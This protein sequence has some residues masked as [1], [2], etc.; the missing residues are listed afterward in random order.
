MEIENNVVDLFGK[1]N[2]AEKPGGDQDTLKDKWLSA[3]EQESFKQTDDSLIEENNAKA[4]AA[5]RAELELALAQNQ[6]L[7]SAQS[8]LRGVPQEGFPS[9]AQLMSPAPALPTAYGPT[10]RPGGELPGMP[11]RPTPATNAALTGGA[12]KPPMT[13]SAPGFVQ[14]YEAMVNQARFMDVNIQ[15]TQ[16]KDGV[17]LWIRDCKQKYSSEVFQW[18]NSLE[19]LL[20]ENGQSLSR[21]MLNGKNI[22]NINAIFGG[23]HGN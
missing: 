21:I 10:V 5:Q 7:N 15:L 18:T 22:N 6:R 3:L 1:V 4:Q 23:D 19:N 8:L 17:T 13:M 11:H 12:G 16:S 2:A 9:A 20:R 14:R